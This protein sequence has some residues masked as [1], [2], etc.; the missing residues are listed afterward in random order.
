[1]E[2]SCN[3]GDNTE[4]RTNSDGTYGDR[5]HNDCE[6]RRRQIYTVGGDYYGSG[7]NTGCGRTDDNNRGGC[8]RTRMMWAAA[9]VDAMTIDAAY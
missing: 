3:G 2:N 5:N 9:T 1:M 6:R 7:A 8:V 4:K